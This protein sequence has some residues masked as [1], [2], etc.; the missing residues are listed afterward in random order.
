MQVRAG[1]VAGA[2]DDPDLLALLFDPLALAD[3]ELRL[4]RICRGDPVPADDAVV[5]DR[6]VAIGL[7]DHSHDHSAIISG[8][9]CAPATREVGPGVQLPVVQDRVVAHAVGRGDDT[10]ERAARTTAGALDGLAVALS[11]LGRRAP[12]DL[13]TEVAGLRDARLVE[14]DVARGLGPPGR[15]GVQ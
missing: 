7:A 9:D 11:Q 1:G 14:G 8:P 12:L 3:Q 6:E 2:A 4:V 13:G 10:G 5:D 15:P